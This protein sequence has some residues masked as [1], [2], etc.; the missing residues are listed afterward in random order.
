MRSPLLFILICVCVCSSSC[1]PLLGSDVAR[2]R[3]MRDTFCWGGLAPSSLLLSSLS[4]HL[5][6]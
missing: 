4:L 3:G 5:L 2:P 1:G 6:V